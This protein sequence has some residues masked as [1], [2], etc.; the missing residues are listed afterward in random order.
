MKEIISEISF[1]SGGEPVLCSPR[2]NT[3]LFLA[4]F[5]LFST[6]GRILYALVMF[7]RHFLF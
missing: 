7:F 6:K 3:A 5:P 1:H 2:R 4:S